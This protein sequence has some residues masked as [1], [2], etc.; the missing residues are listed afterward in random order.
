MNSPTEKT[1]SKKHTSFVSEPIGNKSTLEIPGIGAVAAKSFADKDVSYL[2]CF[3]TIFVV[4]TRLFLDC[5][6]ISAGG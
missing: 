1:A 3:L 5:I 2:Y 4:F 6:C